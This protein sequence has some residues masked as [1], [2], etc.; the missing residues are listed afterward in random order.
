MSNH[1]HDE[2]GEL[3]FEQ[4]SHHGVGYESRDL[5][6][7]GIVGFLILLGVTVAVLCAI[8]WGFYDYRMG[9][10]P[11]EQPVTGVP[12]GSAPSAT[13]LNPA[14][15]FPQPA[16]QVDDVA[17]MQHMLANE[18]LVL[19]SYGWVDK[20]SGIVRIPIDQAMQQ[21][22]KQGLPVRP[23]PQ[24]P[25]AA[26]FGSGTDTVPGFGGGTRPVARQ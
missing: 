24:L 21:I 11:V 15:R 16:L 17:D 9:H 19:N 25:Q 20:N 8:L 1:H 3:H 7:R 23:A 14:K 4:I 22:V 5:G 26:Q 12:E 6:A 2:G 18:D 10:L 13:Q